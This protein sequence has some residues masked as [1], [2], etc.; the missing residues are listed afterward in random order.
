MTQNRKPTVFDGATNSPF[1]GMRAVSAQKLPEIPAAFRGGKAG[2]QLN[3][4]FNEIWYKN[5]PALA[6]LYMG[7]NEFGTRYCLINGQFYF[8]ESPEFKDQLT[9]IAIQDIGMSELAP[10][11]IEN[12]IILLR[13][14]SYLWFKDAENITSPSIRLIAQGNNYVGYALKPDNIIPLVLI[15][16]NDS[17]AQGVFIPS[18]A[19]WPQYVETY[20]TFSHQTL[21]AAR[22]NPA[23]YIT[24]LMSLLIQIGTPEKNEL[25][26]LTGLIHSLIAK[27]HLLIEIT[28]ED[29][30]H[31]LTVFRAIKT[32]I[33]DTIEPC[34]PLP[35]KP[36]EIKRCAFD[37][38]LMSFEF[39]T[40]KVL[41]D[42]VQSSLIEILN[43]TAVADAKPKA[44]YTTKCRVK[45][46]IITKAPTSVFDLPSLHKR[47]L[48]IHLSKNLKGYWNEVDIGLIDKARLELLRLTLMVSHAIYPAYN[49][50]ALPY[51]IDVTG[52]DE[53]RDFILLGC[54][55]SQLMY[56]T[57]SNF[58]NQFHQWTTE[59]LLLQLDGNDCAYLVYLWAKDHPA[60]LATQ[61]LKEWLNELSYYADSEG[62]ELE[63]ISPRKLGADL[64]KASLVLANLGISCVSNGRSTRLS[65][66][67]FSVDKNIGLNESIVITERNQQL[68]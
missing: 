6:S 50:Q 31:C 20:Y 25:I 44:K 66:W 42:D 14:N 12:L 55:V 43:G 21:I 67:T 56:G 65:S 39:H 26:L 4:L 38:Y 8:F 47:T 23:N 13:T 29:E 10:K 48:S 37:E 52:F 17:H 60:S 9:K 19:K 18:Q 53:M 28:G 36:D 33:D 34:K 51:S 61:P 45:R 16:R 54:E 22:S 24:N 62:I 64:K 7:T 41:K 11:V 63:N 15:N 35:K 27:R 59:N 40:D 3:I 5:F 30:A 58:V 49:Q 68:F 46:P 1:S 2:Q 57:P 32:I